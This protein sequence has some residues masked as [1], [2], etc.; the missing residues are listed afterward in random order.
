[1]KTKRLK[2]KPALIE[3]PKIKKDKNVIEL[4][5]YIHQDGYQLPVYPTQPM[6]MPFY[7]NG[8]GPSYN[9]PIATC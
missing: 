4:H 6:P 7:P 2:I 3:I 5:I 1:M 9:Q 8:T